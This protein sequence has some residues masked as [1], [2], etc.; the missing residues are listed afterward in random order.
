VFSC[1]PSCSYFSGRISIEMH[2]RFHR[3]FRINRNTQARALK[4]QSTST[5]QNQSPI[6][7]KS[8]K[9]ILFDI[10]GTL[11]DSDPLHFKTF[12]DMLMEAG[13]DNGRPIDEQFFRTKISGRHNPLIVED[14]FP[15]WAE[16]RRTWFYET[17]EARYREM[18][19]SS[20]ML[21]PLEG[22]SSLIDWIETRGIRRVAVT[23]APRDN[24]H[25]MLKVLKLDSWFEKVV[26]GEECTRA[27]PFPDP[28]LE[29]LRQLGME[30]HETIVFE[31]SPSGI[32]AAVAAGI[33]TIGLL[34]G[35]SEEVLREAGATMIV[36]DFR[37][38]VALI[39]R[40]GAY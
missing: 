36:K 34:T 30:A 38:V 22:L 4:Q 27:K 8:I 11:S 5:M 19:S 15:D 24:A 40:E 20:G 16:D 1:T 7:F 25:L 17:K 31:D 33:P 23:N 32:R 10:D 28:Y 26:L 3:G 12:Q 37:D 39:E 2:L 14:L 9:G 35:Q 21:Q 18:A 6:S 13:F 29:G